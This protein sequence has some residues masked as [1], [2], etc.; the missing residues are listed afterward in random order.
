[1]QSFGSAQKEDSMKLRSIVT[2]ALFVS[3]LAFPAM[4]ASEGATQYKSKCAA[5]HGA[6]GSGDTPMGK[7][8]KVTDL[9]SDAVQKQTDLQ[10]M[11]VISGGK[12]KMPAYG[13]RMSTEEIKDVIAF[14]RT[15]K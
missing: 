13:K 12:G 14:I 2:V 9:R 4:A 10:L 7:S 11:K 8:L 6:N 3:A 5:C 15:L 1:L